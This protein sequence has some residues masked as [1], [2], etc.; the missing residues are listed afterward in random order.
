MLLARRLLPAGNKAWHFLIMKGHLIAQIA[1]PDDLSFIYW[2]LMKLD[3]CLPLLD[4]S[5][6]LLCK[7]LMSILNIVVDSYTNFKRGRYLW[8]WILHTPPHVQKDGIGR[9]A[10]IHWH[11]GWSKVLHCLCTGTTRSRRA[12][13]F[14]REMKRVG[15]KVAGPP[16][17]PW[18]LTSPGSRDALGPPWERSCWDS[19]LRTQ[20]S[21][22]SGEVN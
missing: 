3:S 14:E 13:L 18:L 16:G 5:C 21:S 7:W 22:T 19:G 6:L 10:E 8:R 9:D 15:K 1:L 17:D 4:A 2:A 12:L 20:S 11:T